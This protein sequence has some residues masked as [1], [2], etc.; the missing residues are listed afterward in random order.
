[1]GYPESEVSWE[2]AENLRAPRLVHQFHKDNP[3]AEKGIKCAE[4]PQKRRRH[5]QISA[6]S[7]PCPASKLCL[8]EQLHR[9]SMTWPTPVKAAYTTPRHCTPPFTTNAQPL[10]TQLDKKTKEGSMSMMTLTSFEGTQHPLW[11]AF[12]VPHQGSFKTLGTPSHLGRRLVGSSHHSPKR[13]CLSGNALGLV[14]G[15]LWTP[16]VLSRAPRPDY[17]MPIHSVQHVRQHPV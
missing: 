8:K 9:A 12:H 3:A 1:V 17:S 5:Q 14:V 13:I 16:R 11:D 15:R 2:P 6:S 4:H 7:L 10:G